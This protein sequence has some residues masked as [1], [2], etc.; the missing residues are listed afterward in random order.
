[1]IHALMNHQDDSF[2]KGELMDDWL[3]EYPEFFSHP[4]FSLN[5]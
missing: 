1:M 3:D 4:F 5:Y 2:H